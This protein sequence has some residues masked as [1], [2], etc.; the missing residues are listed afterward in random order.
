MRTRSL[1]SQGHAHARF[2]R[3]LD[4]GNATDAFSAAAELPHV[5]L[6]EALELCLLLRDDG[7][8]FDR[9]IVL[10]RSLCD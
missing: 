4:R 9:A 3:A 6:T 8:K 1:T 5:G 7:A 2:R 10:A